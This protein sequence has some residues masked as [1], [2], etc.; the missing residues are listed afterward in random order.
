MHPLNWLKV[1]NF[2]LN[3]YFFYYRIKGLCEQIRIR[4]H[5]VINT[6][7]KIFFNIFQ[8][9]SNNSVIFSNP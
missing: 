3:I 6:G 2:K 1:A 5:N 4:V 7:N 8:L 9:F